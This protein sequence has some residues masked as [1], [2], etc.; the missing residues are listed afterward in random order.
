MVAFTNYKFLSHNS[1]NYSFLE[2]KLN[3]ILCEAYIPFCCETGVTSP[4]QKLDRPIFVSIGVLFLC[5]FDRRTGVAWTNF[6]GD[7]GKH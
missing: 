1:L 4:L 5:H 6:L 7:L 2:V 3:F